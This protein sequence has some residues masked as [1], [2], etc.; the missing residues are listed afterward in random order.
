MAVLFAV[1]DGRF[2]RVFDR[3]VDKPG[4]QLARPRQVWLHDTAAHGL[5]H[6]F[7]QQHG[8]ARGSPGLAERFQDRHRVA[9]RNPLAQQVLQHSLH[10]RHRQQLRHQIFDHLGIFRADAVEQL[11]RFLAREELMRV[12][13]DQLRKM[14]AKHADAVDHRIARVARPVGALR[15][16]PQRGHAER[17][18][19]CGCALQRGVRRAHGNGQ[20]AALR[21]LV[22][23]DLH[24]LEQD[25]IFARAQR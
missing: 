19:P 13:P 5:P 10:R 1:L 3:R 20:I 24:A 14:R 23:R 15:R 8:I 17:R 9:N 18:L 22:A 16:N 7:G 21:Q 2:H 6:I 12:T 25:R 11:F 4:R